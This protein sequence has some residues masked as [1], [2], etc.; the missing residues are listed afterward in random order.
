[1][2]VVLDTNVLISAIAFGG[3]PRQILEAVFRGEIAL[4]LSEYIL[5]EL[6]AVL[7]RPKFGFPSEVILTILSELHTIGT[8]VTPS[9][10]ILEIQEDT[11]DNRIIECAVAARANYII[12]GD[13][14]LLN[15]KQYQNVRIVSPDEYLAIQSGNEKQ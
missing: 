1:M 6:K 12:S 3:K 10:R 9:T 5:D 11:D 13:T 7:E 15:L 14:H 8:F 2:K 4:F